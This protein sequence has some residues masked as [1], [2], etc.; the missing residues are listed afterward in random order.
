MTS[1]HDASL[2]RNVEKANEAID[3]F[4]Q[5][6]SDHLHDAFSKIVNA[7]GRLVDEMQVLRLELDLAQR[8][9]AHIATVLR[10]FHAAELSIASVHPILVLA[11]QLNHP[12]LKESR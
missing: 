4:L 11:E 8:E 6:K 10:T 1:I 9:H 12:D 3:F 5:P 7:V 2:M